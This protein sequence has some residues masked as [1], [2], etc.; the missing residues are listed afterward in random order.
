MKG[1]PAYLSSGLSVPVE[2]FDPS[3]VGD[4]SGLDPE[5]ADRL[6]E[7]KLESVVALGLATMGSDPDAYSIEILPAKLRARREFVG[8]TLLAIVAAVLAGI[9]LVYQGFRTS[10]ELSEVSEVVAGLEGQ[11]RRAESTDRKARDLLDRNAELAQV[12]SLLLGV[13]GSGEQLA[14][15]LDHM[16]R[17]LPEGFWIDSLGSDWSFDDGLGILRGDDRPILRVVGRAREGTQSIATL[18]DQFVSGLRERFPD[19]RFEY[20]PSPSGDKFDLEFTLFAPPDEGLQG[21]EGVG[22]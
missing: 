1:L 9:F 21:E 7:L 8:G 16:E 4:S 18:L 10:S 2:L 11:L 12:G 5:A 22:G 17:T 15:A 19:S 14:R 3:H 13:A 6:E 20:A